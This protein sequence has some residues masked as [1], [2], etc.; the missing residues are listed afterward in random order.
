MPTACVRRPGDV[1]GQRGRSG[2]PVA[3]GRGRRATASAGGLAGW[4]RPAGRRRPCRPAANARVW[5][6]VGRGQA[7]AGG[8]RGAR[9]REEQDAM[10]ETP[11][12]SPGTGSTR[13]WV[14]D[15]AIALVVTALQVAGTY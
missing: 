13:R 12:I 1:V 3:V 7:Q 9:G 8:G 6:G 5:V 14:V 4:C 2:S 15:A 10:N 11:G